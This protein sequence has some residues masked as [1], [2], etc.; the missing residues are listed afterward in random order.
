M[1]TCS[2]CGDRSAEAIPFCHSCHTPRVARSLEWAAGETDSTAASLG[3]AYPP[4]REKEQA[5]TEALN[6]FRTALEHRDAERTELG[7][8]GYLW[9]L[10]PLSCCMVF[11]TDDSHTLWS[12]LAGA[13]AIVI[14]VVASAV[15]LVRQSSARAVHLALAPI[16]DSLP[17]DARDSARRMPDEALTKMTL[18]VLAIVVM[19]IVLVVGTSRPDS[20]VIDLQLAVLL[21]LLAACFMAAPVLADASIASMRAHRQ[22]VLGGAAGF[23]FIDQGAKRRWSAEVGKA[24]ASALRFCELVEHYKQFEWLVNC[25]MCGGEGERVLAEHRQSNDDDP[26]WHPILN[27]RYVNL[28]MHDW[29]RVGEEAQEEWQLED[30]THVRWQSRIVRDTCPWC[31]GIGTAYARFS[32]QSGTCKT[33]GG[34]G[35]IEREIRERVDVG[36]QHRMV[37]EACPACQGTGVHTLEEVQIRSLRLWLRTEEVLL[38]EHEV[39]PYAMHRKRRG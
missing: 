20:T 14:A 38:R 19:I 31:G 7:A 39:T 2:A 32:V 3:L 30:G 8:L 1:W 37:V 28:G 4:A 36:V 17:A 6:A 29:H 9:L 25:P 16:W 35:T 12:R 10:G 13:S 33:C 22:R 18:A 23:A 27:W 34:G 21:L 24:N 11:F 5:E 26:D 15:V